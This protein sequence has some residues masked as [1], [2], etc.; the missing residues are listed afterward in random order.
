MKHAFLSFLE[1]CQ[2]VLIAVIAVVV[3]RNFIAQPFLVDGR[4]MEPTFHNGDY[5]LIDQLTYRLRDPVRGEPVVFLYPNDLKQETYY[6]KRIIGLPGERIV[7]KEGEITVYSG[8]TSRVLQEM[9]A[10]QSSQGFESLDVTL[11]NDQYFVMGDNR[12]A[13][14][15]SRSWGPLD[16]SFVVGLARFRLWP[17]SQAQAFH[18]PVYAQ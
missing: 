1:V 2:T 6:I 10:L 3:V 12:G 8:E 5:L 11:H 4:S 14:Y 18:A 16:R 9:Y 15:D 17:V 13:S 7:M